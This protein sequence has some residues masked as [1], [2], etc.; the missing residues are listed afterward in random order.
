MRNKILPA[1]L[2]SLCASSASYAQIFVTGI[3]EKVADIRSGG[4]GSYPI[5][6]TNY[7]SD[8]YFSAQTTAS[9]KELWKTGGTA[10]TTA[11]LKDLNPGAGGS[12]PRHFMAMNGNLY[13][14]A[15]DGTKI[16]VWKTDGTAAGT[17][18]VSNND[19]LD[20]LFVYNNMLL[21]AGVGANGAELWK[22]DGTSAGTSEVIDLSPG[23]DN[24]SP[25]GFTQLDTRVVFAASTDGSNY[26]PCITDGT[27]LGTEA[28]S[29]T[30]NVLA[31]TTL[32]SEYTGKE[33]SNFCVF[34]GEAYFAAND[35]TNGYEL[36]KTDGTPAGTVMV[37]DIAPAADASMPGGFKVFN[38]KLYFSVNTGNPAIDG[39]WT[40]NG[41]AA[42]TGRL[43]GGITMGD[44]DV[45]E[46][47]EANGNLYFAANGKLWVTDGTISG[48]HVMT[49]SPDDPKRF[50]VLNN[51][52]FF[53]ATTSIMPTMFSLFF[54]DNMNMLS[55][56]SAPFS[57]T[58][59]PVIHSDT[60]NNSLYFGIAMA[61]SPSDVE[62][63]RFK[64]TTFELAVNEV[65]AQAASNIYPNP[66]TNTFSVKLADNKNASVYVY[67]LSGQLLLQ[68]KRTEDIDIAQLPAG[69]Y[70]VQIINGG[71][72]SVGKLRKQ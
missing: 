53:F 12:F 11:L 52:V 43:K 41:T 23:V 42:G 48:T 9:D 62:L 1:L 13:F 35:G 70:T 30:V 36:W 15:T 32:Y 3:I 34:N 38:G 25:T 47:A 8:I 67:S 63:Y 68:T 21:F 57:N 33:H 6:L 16:L 18:Q 64:D 65:S 49:D 10:A 5:Y 61:T 71:Q 44:G 29:T 27:A 66:A 60:M 50:A 7:N 46:Y 26:V 45:I 2:L 39:L 14:L 24:S 20:E 72:V 31:P 54:V 19:M 22:S 56:G 55:P 40:T 37:K 51:K 59:L 69:I 17:Q 58:V 28:L 4:S